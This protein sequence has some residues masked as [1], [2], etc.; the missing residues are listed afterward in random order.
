MKTE[1]PEISLLE[2]HQLMLLDEIQ[3]TVTQ[4][5]AAVNE[6]NKKTVLPALSALHSQSDS[7]DSL[8]KKTKELCL[9]LIQANFKRLNAEGKIAMPVP[10]LASLDKENNTVQ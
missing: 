5:C 7:V 10:D 3:S 2:A 9:H 1:T 6:N 4:A 8:L